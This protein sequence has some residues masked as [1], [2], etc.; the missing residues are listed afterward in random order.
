MKA[1][2][3]ASVLIRSIIPDQHTDIVRQWLAT[4]G[5]LLAPQLVWYEV[6]SVLRHMEYLQLVDQT[7]VDRSLEQ[8]LGIPVVVLGRKSHYRIMVHLARK[9]NVSRAYDMAYLALAIEEECPLV[10]LDSRLINNATN[11][12]YTVLHPAD[13]LNS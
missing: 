8:L 7:V 10:T 9:L 1:V 2:V 12:G 13:H 11:H 4:A 6:S 3:D 5:E